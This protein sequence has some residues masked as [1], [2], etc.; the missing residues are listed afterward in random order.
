MATHDH[1]AG[2]ED[3]GDN[4]G[5]LASHGL[6]VVVCRGSRCGLLRVFGM[7]GATNVVTATKEL[8]T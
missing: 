2:N 8:A 4:C 3:A 6:N 5:V 1:D 7:V